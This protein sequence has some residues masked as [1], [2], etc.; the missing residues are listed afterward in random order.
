MIVSS[1]VR[2][3]DLGL[4]G[5]PWDA[6]WWEGRARRGS[7]GEKADRRAQREAAQCSRLLRGAQR[8]RFLS[9]P[10]SAGRLREGQ[11]Q[12]LVRNDGPQSECLPGEIWEVS[13]WEKR[14]F[15]VKR[16]AWDVHAHSSIYSRHHFLTPS[17]GHGCNDKSMHSGV[18]LPWIA[19]VEWQQECH[20][21]SLRGRQTC[22]NPSGPQWMFS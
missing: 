20:T 10:L 21:F 12:D 7:C 17:G 9:Y 4:L 19:G 18:K 14:A 13:R 15:W 6:S 22:R 2:I 11:W 3:S 16:M 8:R 5:P 1:R